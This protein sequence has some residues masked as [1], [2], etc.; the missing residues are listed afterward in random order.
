MSNKDRRADL[1][2]VMQ[3]RLPDLTVAARV[4]LMDIITQVK[5]DAASM[6]LLAEIFLV[7]KEK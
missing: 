7:K 1:I 2:R 5:A 4:Q 3:G 6:A